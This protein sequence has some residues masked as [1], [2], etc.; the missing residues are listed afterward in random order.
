MNT[1]KQGI[2]SGSFIHDIGKF[3][4]RAELEKEYSEIKDNYNDFCPTPYSYLHAAHSAF[5]VEKFLPETLVSK[6][7]KK[8]LYDAC[9]HH[10]DACDK[11]FKIADRLSSGM[12]R[13]GSA[14]DGG[15]YKSTR[16]VSIFDSVEVLYKNDVKPSWYYD[17]R[18]LA[19]DKELFPV[20]NEERNLVQEY[21]QLWTDFEQELNN[22]GKVQISNFH[23]LFNEL[24]YL[25]QKYTWCIPSAT[26]KLPDIS[27]FD[28]LKT[29]S[30]IAACLYDVQQ[31]GES[32]KGKEFLLFGL[33]LSG[34]QSFIF[35][36]TSALGIGGISRRLRGRSFYLIMLGEILA[37]YAVNQLDL[38][39]ANINFCG[40]GNIELLLANTGKT[41]EFLKQFES[42]VNKWLLDKFSGQIAV[43]MDGLAI[44][45][46]DLQNNFHEK[47][48]ELQEMIDLKK[49]RKFET[50]F[51]FDSFL[52]KTPSSSLITVCPSCNLTQIKKGQDICND[53]KEH[54]KIG[55]ELPK[56]KALVFI[57]GSDV[58]PANNPVSVCFGK[59]GKIY[60]LSK[61]DTDILNTDETGY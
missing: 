16:L 17:L 6:E 61:P 40:G 4:Q 60:L 14:E 36:I 10:L 52:H 53:C 43:A 54:K 34:I 28:H 8:Y 45:K 49:K 37:R 57:L 18:K 32:D 55:E 31:H 51:G 26:N 47:K 2:V 19:G 13:T 24:F 44:S 38:T 20:R 42:D 33:D 23:V 29:T 15:N 59:F 11:I 46:S 39:I 22:L 30:A 7:M 1:E 27:L 58:K 12:D 48:R 9:R 21:Q 56:T 35:R 25:L 50:H 3:M 41:D 5:F